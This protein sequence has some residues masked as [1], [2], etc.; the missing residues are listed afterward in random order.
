MQIILI[1]IV[2]GVLV[3]IY[4]VF[5]VVLVYK[6]KGTPKV[7]NVRLIAVPSCAVVVLLA[8]YLQQYVFLGGADPTILDVMVLNI[9]MAASFSLFYWLNRDKIG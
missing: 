4:G 9:S 7:G 8:F 1:S 3:G 6:Y 5:A 2:L